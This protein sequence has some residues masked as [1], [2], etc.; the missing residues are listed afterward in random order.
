MKIYLSNSKFKFLAGFIFSL[1]VQNFAQAETASEVRAYI[2]SKLFFYYVYNPN[3]DTVPILVE[4]KPDET[5]SREVF[6]GN[7]HM[8]NFTVFLKAILNDP[9]HG[10]KES[11]QQAF[12]EILGIRNVKVAMWMYNDEHP[13]NKH[14]KKYFIDCVDDNG[15]EWP[16][17]VNEGSNGFGGYIHIGKHFLSTESPGDANWT[18]IH[19]LIHTQDMSTI[20]AEPFYIHDKWYVYG[21]DDAHYVNEVIPSS[22]YAF[23]EGIANAFAYQYVYNQQDLPNISKWFSKDTEIKVEMAAPKPKPG[24]TLNPD[25]F[26]YKQL[27]DAH[28]KPLRISDGY[29]V[30]K[31]GQLT[32][33]ILIH[34]EMVI[35]NMLYSFMNYISIHRVVKA[36][37]EYNLQGKSVFGGKGTTESMLTT[38]CQI[39]LPQMV[40]AR[41]VPDCGM[42][43]KRKEHLLP[44]A[45]ADFFTWFTSKSETEFAQAFDNGMNMDLIHCYWQVREDVIK[46]VK[47]EKNFSLARIDIAIALGINSSRPETE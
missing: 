30:Y 21:A 15:Y 45:Y 20:N 14:A 7:K 13:L 23:N 9:A 25:L 17:A 38:L 12:K 18:V 1:L 22:E 16:C 36:F 37:T 4:M 34:N 3:R 28:V 6:N 29:A 47:E 46:A 2:R 5:D 24:E 35:A 27:K 42:Y 31:L 32:P 44:L 19:E 40:R 43:P 10:G 39:S 41:S 26:I 11:I 8:K 33:K